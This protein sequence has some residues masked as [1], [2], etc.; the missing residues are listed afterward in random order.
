MGKRFLPMPVRNTDCSGVSTRIQTRWQSMLQFSG[1]PEP[2]DFDR[3][4]SECELLMVQRMPDRRPFRALIE[5]VQNLQRH[6][7]PDSPI[8]FRLLGRCVE[9]EPRFL[10]QTVNTLLHADVGR[11]KDWLQRHERWQRDVSQMAKDGS[12]KWRELHRDM[13]ESGERTPR[14]GAGL[15]WVSMAR[16]AKG[17]P[18]IRM[19]ADRDVHRLFFSVEVACGG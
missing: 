10:I 13:L 19:I 7:A 3:I 5:C 16:F 12:R 1:I 6:S 18:S 8:E 17:T 4:L 9:G 11:V 14:G 2:G 15:G